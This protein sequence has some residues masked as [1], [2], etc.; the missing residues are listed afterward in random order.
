MKVA[1]IDSFPWYFY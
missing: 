1:M